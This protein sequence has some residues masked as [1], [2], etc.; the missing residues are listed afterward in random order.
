MASA[1]L[2]LIAPEFLPASSPAG[3]WGVGTAEKVEIF[4]V[5][6]KEAEEYLR[7]RK[8]KRRRRGTS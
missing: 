4:F 2:E 3:V 8:A 7:F 6:K 5:H 1:K